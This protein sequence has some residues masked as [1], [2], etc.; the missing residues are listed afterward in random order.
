M[1]IIY[2]F[3]FVVIIA[4]P[5]IS[6]AKD[7]PDVVVGKYLEAVRSNNYDK[8]YSFISETDTTIIDWLEFIKYV[9]EITPPKLTKVIDLAH[10]A[11]RQEIVSTSI[12]DNVAI[13]KTHSIV[14][15]MEE[16][17]KVTQDPGEIKFLLDHGGAP[18]KEK[19]GECKLVIEN[20]EWKI[21]HV[22]GV[23][24]R[25]AA[26]IATS[27]A[28]LLLG[29]EEAQLISE[30]IDAFMRERE[31]VPKESGVKSIY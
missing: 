6:Y 30:K 5:G 31:E 21:F 11:T 12:M 14:P 10:S 4:F 28:V 26:D 7:S 15:D 8:A 25:Q 9:Q 29:E 18:V 13:V 19:S 1:R 20:G 3:L 23:S 24:S 2:V 17:L 22:R 27:F 16:T